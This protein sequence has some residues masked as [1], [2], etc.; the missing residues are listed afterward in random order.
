M[1]AYHGGEDL[2][3]VELFDLDDIPEADDDSLDEEYEN[4]LLWEK[5]I[6]QTDNL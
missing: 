1:D 2:P 4:Y 6:N 5:E 3:D